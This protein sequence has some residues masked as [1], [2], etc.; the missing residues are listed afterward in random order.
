MIGV[1][2]GKG[3]NAL[4]ARHISAAAKLLCLLNEECRTK[5]F[6]YDV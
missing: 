4:M 6:L 5:L 3:G 1:V 2:V